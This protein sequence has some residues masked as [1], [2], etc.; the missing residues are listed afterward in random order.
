M[1][2]ASCLFCGGDRSAPD[3]ARRCD[4]R[5]GVVDA[6]P[7]PSFDPV[8]HTRRTDPDTSAAAA[9]A[10]TDATEVQRRVLSIHKTHPAGLTDEEL[11]AAYTCTYA[12][13]A[14]SLESRSSPR[15][16]RSDLAHA[17]VLV[18]SGERR[19]LTSGRNGVVWK[20]AS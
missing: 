2:I 11:I 20:V 14:R 3:H 19:P 6:E 9:W 7:L 4:G 10:I 16:R 12:P 15:K 17:G 5:Q 18:D 1:M 13:S 8:A